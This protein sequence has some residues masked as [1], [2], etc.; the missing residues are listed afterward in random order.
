MRIL[1]TFIIVIFNIVFESTFLHAIQI[2]GILPN[3]T[4]I[5]I[6][7]FALLRGKY[8]GAF[9]GFLCG[10]LHDIFFGRTK[11]YFALIG[12]LMGYIVGKANKNFFRESY[13]ISSIVTAIST[14]IFNIIIYITNFML[15]GEIGFLNY[16]IYILLP[17]TVYTTIFSLRGYRI[18]YS[19]NEMLESKE[20]RKR[21]R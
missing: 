10:L 19:I 14:I 6:V 20:Q 18:L 11:F 21:F 5:I 4:L 7:S 16:F 15:D 12:L 3:T 1:I 9:T 2:R 13:V 17:E 8:E